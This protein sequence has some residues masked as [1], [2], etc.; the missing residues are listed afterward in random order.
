M[1]KKIFSLITIIIFNLNYGFAG[2]KGN[3]MFPLFSGYELNT[4]FKVYDPDNLWDYINGGAYTY[5]NYQFV[6]LHIAEY[7]K[8]DQL[9]KAEIYKHK[10]NIYAFGIYAQE[11]APDYNFVDVGVQGY[12]E[13]T[14]VN[15]VKGP[16][17]VKVLCNDGDEGTKPV[18]LDLARKIASNLEGSDKMPGLFTKFP[19]NGK[20][21]NSESYIATE[22]LGYSFMPGVYVTA[23]NGDEGQ[24]R[25][26]IADAGNSEKAA[27]IVGKLKEKAE[28]SKKKKGVLTL[29]DP[30]NGTVML[31]QKDN[32]IYGCVD[33]CDPALFKVFTGK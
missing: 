9:I 3:G 22:F 26:F 18:L 14:L 6:D 17:Y 10:N 31:T 16:Y 1:Q 20:I 4:D 32:L 28:K 13:N 30:Y 27:E 11:R 7:T 2:E 21:K 23:Y 12:A 25:L 29:H 19:E 33:N 8:G 15:F 5:L 24:A